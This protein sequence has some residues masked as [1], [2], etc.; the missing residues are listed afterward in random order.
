MSILRRRT[1]HGACLLAL[2]ALVSCG[3]DRRAVSGDP[4]AGRQLFESSGCGGCHTFAAAGSR[5]RRGPSFDDGRPGAADVLAQL[6]QGGGLMPSFADDLTEREMRD[7]ASF[8]GTD[9]APSAPFRPDRRVRS[10]C[11]PDDPECLEQVYG[12]LVFRR[13]P[14][15]ALA[16]LERAMVADAPLHADCHRVAHRMGSAALARAGD[17]VAP[18][19]VAGSPVC[20]SGYYHGVIERAFRGQPPARIGTLARQ[21]CQDPAIGRRLYLRFQ[22]LHGLGHGLMLHT[23][24]DLPESLRACDRLQED[25]GRSSCYGGTFMENFNTSYGVTSKYVRRSDPLYPCPSV[26]ERFKA[27]CYGIVTSNVLRLTG[28]DLRRTAAA[29]RRSEPRWVAACLQS[30]G[31]DVSGRAGDSAAAPLAG[32][33][34]AAPREGDCVVGVAQEI[35]NADAGPARASRFCARA[36]ATLRG[37]CHQAIGSVLSSL[38][39]AGEPVRAACRRASGR[40]AASCIRGA[41]IRGA[42]G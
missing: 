39:A 11:A 10:D 5:G 17:R 32:C 1:G 30:Y 25:F 24:Y 33:R 27:Q 12:N 9:S 35:V 41:G 15:A 28:D 6:R 22:C 31:R 2:V 3:G 37:R 36:A 4:V 18:A 16:V 23:G 34:L 40:Y 8:V 20:A 29:C 13:G 14:K 19:F 26:A 21:L 7:I 38:V 42:K